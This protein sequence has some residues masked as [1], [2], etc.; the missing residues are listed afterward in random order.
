MSKTVLNTIHSQCALSSFAFVE[1][2]SYFLCFVTVVCYG[3]CS[4][5]NP[6]VHFLP[7][8]LLRVRVTF[9]A[10]TWLSAMGAVHYRLLWFLRLPLSMDRIA[11]FALSRL[12]AIR[13]VCDLSIS[14]EGVE[15][16][17]LSASAF[18]FSIYTFGIA[19]V[20]P[21]LY[22]PQLLSVIHLKHITLQLC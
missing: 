17:C 1:G 9:F 5:Y 12:S 19:L 6:S 3:H 7:L 8:P 2:Q 20:F 10:L 14:A 22:H 11:L 13:A 4:I 21:F 15:S 16:T 18:V